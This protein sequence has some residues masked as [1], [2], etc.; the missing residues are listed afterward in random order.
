MKDISNE[1][2][3]QEI[4]RRL[5]GCEQIISEQQDMLA[6]LKDLNRKL[7]QSEAL[8]SHFISNIKNEI[9]NPLASIL[10]L[11]QNVLR[12]G[13]Q[14]SPE[15]SKSIRLI[16]NEAHALDFQLDNIMTAA[17]IEAGQVSPR[18]D[19]ANVSTIIDQVIHA[20][21]SS[22]DKKKINI[23]VPEEKDIHFVTDSHYFK[24]IVANLVSNAV[25]FSREEG[26]VAISVSHGGESL[27]IDVVDA[28][29]GISQQDFPRIFDR[30]T[31]LDVGTMKKYQGHGIGLSVIK[32]LVELLD[33]TISVKSSAEGSAFSIVLPVK[34]SQDGLDASLGNGDEIL[35]D[36]SF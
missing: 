5:A 36:Q 18:F 16:Y 9:N 21:K 6:Q 34:F 17:E 35:F 2:L 29:V 27:N 24:I 26:V 32:D 11:S 19:D 12:K 22:I 7:E 8:K 28:G 1:A 15:L 3:L 4:N 25:K 33:G 23:V 30:F 13:D 14:L 31:Q 10:A 20:F